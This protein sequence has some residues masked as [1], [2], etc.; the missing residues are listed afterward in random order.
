MAPRLF[1]EDF[2]VGEV[3]VYGRHEVTRAEIVAFAREFDPQPFHLD[4][5]AGAASIL[6]G[7][8]ASGWHTAGMLMRMT[9]DGWLNDAASM[10]GPGVEEVRWLRPVRP[11]DVLSVRRE[12]LAARPSASRP[13]MGLVTFRFDVLDQAGA[14]AMMQRSVIMLGR[15]PAALA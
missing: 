10:G 2:A 1:F 14:V 13:E 9:A 12:T 11:G 8:C 7:L 4:D 6:G 5:E 3:A 15:R